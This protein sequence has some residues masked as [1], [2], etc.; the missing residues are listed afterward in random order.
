MSEINLPSDLFTEEQFVVLTPAEKEKYITAVL[1]KI[2]EVNPNGV[3]ISQ[4]SKEL[5]YFSRASIWR[6]LELLSATREGYKLNFGKVAIYYPN[7]K[8]IHHVFQNDVKLGENLF[9]FF[10]VKN[11][12]GE[13]L[14]IQEKKEDRLGMKEVCGGLVIPTSRIAEF[15][16]SINK[17]CKEVEK[18][19]NSNTN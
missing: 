7:G 1:K 3:T 17:S 13:F 15:V 4:I 6:H 11:N 18:Y 5:D 10:F 12:F 14:Y 16:D 2:L 8:Q 9:G 19:A